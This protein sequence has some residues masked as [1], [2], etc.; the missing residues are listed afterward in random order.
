[1]VQETLRHFR[2]PDTLAEQREAQAGATSRRY[3]EH[4]FDNPLLAR[5]V[6]TK[7]QDNALFFA[8]S[9]SQS[10]V[11][12]LAQVS[13]DQIWAI[14]PDPALSALGVGVDKRDLNFSMGDYL[15]HLSQGGPLGSRRTGSMLAQG[16]AL[17]GAG[18]IALHL[19]MCLF[20]FALVDL[21]AKRDRQGAVV[22]SAV[23]MLAIW[24]LFQYGVAAESLHAW[25]GLLLRGLPQNIVLF[26]LVALVARALGSLFGPGRSRE[27]SAPLQNAVG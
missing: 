11:R 1:M 22:V 14:L 8:A 27:A 18:F 4:Y 19:L 6:E 12:Q 16:L 25:V 5:L 2:S 26:L 9:L 21:Q 3:D 15:I 17:F 20:A 7:F 24:K 23:G 13:V 10:D